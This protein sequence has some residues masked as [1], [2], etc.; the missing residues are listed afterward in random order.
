MEK[1]QIKYSTL[2]FLL[3]RKKSIPGIRIDRISSIPSIKSKYKMKYFIVDVLIS[4]I[5]IMVQRIYNLLYT[6]IC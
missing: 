4:I 2:A 5:D 3:F 6:S 1:C